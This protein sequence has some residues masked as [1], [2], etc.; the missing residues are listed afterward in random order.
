MS[1]DEI[2]KKQIEFVEIKSAT[3][4]KNQ[5]NKEDVFLYK[6]KNGNS[7]IIVK[8]YFKNSQG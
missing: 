1:K 7:S 8:E 6:S 2:D 5:F 4:E 3:D